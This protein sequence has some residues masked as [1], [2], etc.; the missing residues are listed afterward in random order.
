[1][2]GVAHAFRSPVGEWAA[3]GGLGRGSAEKAGSFAEAGLLGRPASS[4]LE[5][6]LSYRQWDKSPHGVVSLGL[7]YVWDW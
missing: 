6:S 3:F 2:L 1:M 4:R 5:G 7:G